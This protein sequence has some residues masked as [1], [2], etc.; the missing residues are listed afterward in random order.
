LG[1][2]VV[3]LCAAPVLLGSLEA[4]VILAEVGGLAAFARREPARAA[5]LALAG[6]S[7]AGAPP[8][9]GFF[10]EFAVA[11]ALA[12]D[13]LFWLVGVLLVSGLLAVFGALRIVQG[14][15]LEGTEEPGLRAPRRG[16]R[17]FVPASVGGLLVVLLLCAY[18]LFAD[19]ISGLA[20]Q[21][22]EALG[23]R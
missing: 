1:A 14:A 17:V 9:A 6:L 22:A 20:F 16:S 3:A 5:G 18:G 21:G 10:G 7:L 2:A 15:F 8:L 23:L 13:H 19:P 11:A 12:A 4:S